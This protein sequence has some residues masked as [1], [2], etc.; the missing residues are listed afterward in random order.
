MSLKKTVLKKTLKRPKAASFIPTL[1]IER[2]VGFP[3]KFVAGVDEVGRGCIAGPVTAAAVLIPS[4]WEHSLPT[5][6]SEVRDSKQLSAAT[7]ERLAL[8]I[9]ATTI[10][11]IVH[12]S[13]QEIDAINILRASHLAMQ[14]AVESVLA[15]EPQL[16]H[17]LVDGNL[18]PRGFSGSSFSFSPHIKGDQKSI[19]IACA[20]ILAKVE[21]DRVMGELEVEYPGYGLAA[22]KGYPTPSHLK[23]LARQGVTSIYRQ[24]FAPVRALL[25]P[26]VHELTAT[27]SH[28]NSD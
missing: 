5:W 6:M 27:A 12:A 8:E 20:S 2:T 22:H 21:R 10:F 11:A 1:E 7:R 15:R 16:H 9:Q 24:S 23:A 19:A 17:V 3:F 14:R 25:D 18:I 13:V 28:T 26:S 4:G